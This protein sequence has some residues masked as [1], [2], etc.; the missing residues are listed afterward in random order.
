MKTKWISYLF[1]L[2]FITSAY[3]QLNIEFFNNNTVNPA[4]VG[5]KESLSVGIDYSLTGVNTSLERQYDGMPKSFLVNGYKSINKNVGVGISYIN[6]QFGALKSNFVN[7]DA[8]YKLP[9]NEDSKLLFGVKTGLSIYKFEYAYVLLPDGTTGVDPN[10]L[11]KK[12]DFN[13]G[14]GMHYLYKDLTLGLSVP[15]LLQRDLINASSDKINISV[16]FTSLFKTKIGD[17]IDFQPG[18]ML[19]KPSSEDL[20]YYFSADFGF[21]KALHLGLNYQK[22]IFGIQISTPKIADIFVIGLNV[23]FIKGDSDY[24]KNVDFFGNFEF[25]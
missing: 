14:I 12:T 15:N 4:S 1:L 2:G 7:L 23:G 20:I 22:D 13:V 24:N 21:K 3:S 9:V 6:L 5:L 11:K 16:V 10:L 25:H 8:S 18:I 17:K 19:A